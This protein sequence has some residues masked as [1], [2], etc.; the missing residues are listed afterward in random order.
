MLESLLKLHKKFSRFIKYK[1]LRK[2]KY[3]EKMWLK[4]KAKVLQEVSG[5]FTSKYSLDVT[6]RYGTYIFHDKGNSLVR[7]D[8]YEPITQHSLMVLIY[9]DKLR[10]NR[11]VLADIGVNIGLHT[12]YLKDKY[13][14][15]EVIAFDP[16]PASWAYFEFSLKY[17]KTS[18]VHLQKIAL[19]DRNG[20]LDFYRWGSESS[21]DAL[22]DTGRVPGVKPTVIQ[23][24]ARKLDDV[25]DLPKITVIKM[26]C[27]G[28][29]FSILEG[30]RNVL[31]KYK[32]LILLE[33]SPLNI[34][35][36]NI[37]AEKIIEKVH[38]LNYLL[39][40]LDFINI[41]LKMFK[42]MQDEGEEN[43]IMLPNDI[44]LTDKIV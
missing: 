35:A 39:Y 30:S 11:T 22:C 26:D 20:I 14:D 8:G 5:T 1:V 3:K 32:P 21:A 13:Q 16:S 38:E 33:F 19:S 42:E 4:E 28:A 37:N 44:V 36:F 23:V 41:D 10:G 18:N 43:Y 24:P 31:S 40:S 9:L 29:E 12:F 34:G 6:K 7:R 17:N 25:E 15:L 27:E 2:K